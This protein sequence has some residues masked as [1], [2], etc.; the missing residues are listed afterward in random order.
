MH[1]VARGWEN[2]KIEICR[3]FKKIRERKTN[4]DPCSTHRHCHKKNLS[5][6]RF[7]TYVGRDGGGGGNG[8]WRSFLLSLIQQFE[9]FFNVFKTFFFNVLNVFLQFKHV[10]REVGRKV[11]IKSVFI[12]DRGFRL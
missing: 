11:V 9:R 5:Q 12:M 8:W 3:F 4:S 1:V 6:K 10:F 2:F 7:L